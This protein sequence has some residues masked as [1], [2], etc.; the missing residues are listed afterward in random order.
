MLQYLYIFFGLI[1]LVISIPSTSH[2]AGLL[3]RSLQYKLPDGYTIERTP[4]VGELDEVQAYGA[5]IVALINLAYE[6]S[7][8]L[9]DPVS[10]PYPAIT[11]NIT[12]A[13]ETSQYY[14]QFASYTLYH[15]LQTLTLTKDLTVS[16]FTL[17]NKAGAVACKVV[18]APPG[19]LWQQ[20]LGG[21]SGSSLSPRS[22]RHSLPAVLE[23]RQSSSRLG[24]E[25]APLSKL[26]PLHAPDWYGPASPPQDFFMALATMIVKVSDIDDKD[27]GIN[28]QTL[29][30]EGYHLNVTNMPQQNRLYY[31]SNR[32]VLNLCAYAYGQLAERMGFLKPVTSFET[33][34]VW[35]NGTGL[36]NHHVLRYEG[37]VRNG[38]RGC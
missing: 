19:A 31:L 36:V 34:L 32:G 2:P 33:V 38:T 35:S 15:A 20:L 5:I 24:N 9:T 30:E 7:S 3:R 16:N 18:L 1:N 25:T 37:A 12:G 27:R 28:Y 14:R 8:N 21:S 6:D 26:I 29:D 4:G 10:Y 17:Q 11:L 22:T 23:P 13:D